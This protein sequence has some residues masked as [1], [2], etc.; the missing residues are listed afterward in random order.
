M[1][2]LKHNTDLL[3][4]RLQNHFRNYVMTG[5]VPEYFTNARL[6]LLSKFDSDTPQINKTRLIS[7]LPTI[8]KLFETTILY[9]FES[10]I[11]SQIFS[12]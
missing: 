10:V 5:D 1:F 12:K 8:T 7:I 11:Q 2:K 9:D 4:V 3:K 6:I